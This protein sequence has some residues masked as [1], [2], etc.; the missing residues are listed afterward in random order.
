MNSGERERSADGVVTDLR[1]MQVRGPGVAG[2]LLDENFNGLRE[3]V[4][5]EDVGLITC[6]RGVVDQRAR[7]LIRGSAQGFSSEP[8][9]IEDEV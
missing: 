2:G 8:I 7:L 4:V 6:E 3:V 5:V 9:H 1:V